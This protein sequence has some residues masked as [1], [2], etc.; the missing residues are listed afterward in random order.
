MALPDWLPTNIVDELRGS[1]QLGVFLNVQTDPALHLYFGVGDIPA[2]IDSIDPSGTVYYGGGRLNGV[3]SLEMLIM[4]ASSTAEFVLS[5][6]SVDTGARTVVELPPM[7]GKAVYIGITTLDE[8]YQPMSAILP[9]WNGEASHVVEASGPVNGNGD[10][11]MS[12]SLAVTSGE[13]T[14]SRPSRALWSAAMQKA[15]S[16]T[17]RFCDG[18]ARLARGVQPVWPLYS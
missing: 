17:D 18:T 11:T 6:I 4:G 14:R 16:P 13:K 15:L 7:R 2:G 5:G 3:P 12:L 1:H 10:R 8:Y 9:M